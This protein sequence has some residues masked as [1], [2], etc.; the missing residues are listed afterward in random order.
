M[1]KS[2]TN[3]IGFGIVCVVD[4]TVERRICECRPRQRIDGQAEFRLLEYWEHAG[5]HPSIADR[6]DQ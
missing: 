6:N 3:I 4:G 2:E 1:I 5:S